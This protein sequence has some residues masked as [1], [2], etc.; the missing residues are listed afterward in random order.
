MYTLYAG[1]L[2]YNSPPLSFPPQAWHKFFL[3]FTLWLLP[4][5]FY[6]SFMCVEAA[7]IGMEAYSLVACLVSQ[8]PVYRLSLA[9]YGAF[10]PNTSELPVGYCVLP[11]F[12]CTKVHAHLIFY[13]CFMYVEALVLLGECLR[14]TVSFAVFLCT[15]S[16]YFCC[17]PVCSSSVFDSFSIFCYNF[18]KVEKNKE[19]LKLE[20]G[21]DK[22]K[23]NQITRLIEL[24]R[25]VSIAAYLPV[26][27]F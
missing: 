17:V 24:E 13:V 25:D 7:G 4:R 16:C 11:P 20:Q 18:Q 5:S 1:E 8:V 2:C 26:W 23:D 21:D 10:C 14:T 9:R 3:F 19:R 22:S 12:A 27:Q 15:T 6:L